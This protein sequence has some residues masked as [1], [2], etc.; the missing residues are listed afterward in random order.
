M[1]CE[2][3][4]L[5][6]SLSLFLS[7]AFHIQTIHYVPYLLLSSLSPSFLSSLCTFSPLSHSCM[8][9]MYLRVHVYINY[10]CVYLYPSPPSLSL[11]L[12]LSLTHAQPLHYAASQGN[13]QLVKLLLESNANPKITCNLGDTPASVALSNNHTALCDWLENITSSG[14]PGSTQASLPPNPLFS[15]EAQD[16]KSSPR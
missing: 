8:I 7:A 2:S 3:L 1:D 4:S 13:H 15:S 16:S 12:P 6:L 5:S 9:I 10:L 11:S 14:G